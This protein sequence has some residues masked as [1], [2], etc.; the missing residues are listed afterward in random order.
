MDRFESQRIWV[1]RFA[2]TDWRDLY[3]YLS[4]PATYRFEPGEPISEAEAQTLAAA[5]EQDTA[6]WAVALKPG[7]PLIGHLY[8]SQSEPAEFLTWEL[9]YIFNPAYHGQGYCTE[10]CRLLLRHAFTTL[11]AHRVTAHC[12]PANPASWRVLEKLGMR[13]E[14]HFQRH[15]FFRRNAAGEPL[16][17]DGLAYGLLAEEFSG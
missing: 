17:H 9:G 7:G 11:H 16:W 5:R 12:D 8:F 6:F 13:R 3:A 14:G 2:A 1:R 10:A 4:L 15:A